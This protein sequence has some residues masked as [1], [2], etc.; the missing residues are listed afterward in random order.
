MRERLNR[1]VLAGGKRATAGLLTEYEDEDEVLEHVGERL[2]LLD[3]D[4]EQVAT[5]EV[6]SVGT[7]AF[8]DVPWEFAAAEGEGHRDLEHWRADHRRF[9]ALQGTPVED[10]T[11]IV[12][13]GLHVV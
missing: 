2:A 4:G 12:M 6:I 1:L 8:A 3:D 7:A 10:H 5:V 11:P 13:L 9:W